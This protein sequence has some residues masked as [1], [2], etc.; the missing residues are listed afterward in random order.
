ML[1][2]KAKHRH[3]GRNSLFPN[4]VVEQHQGVS[5][6]RDDLIAGGT[7]ARYLIDLF[8][9]HDEV[10]YASPAY[11][12]AQLALAYCARLTGKRATVFVAKRKQPHNRT[13]EAARVGARV[14]QVVHGYLNVVQARAKAYAADMGVHLLPFGAHEER[15]IQAI[16]DVARCVADE[17]GVFDE[18]WCACG[19]GTLL[20]GLMR[21]LDAKR[22]V[23][24]QIGRDVQVSGAT[25][26]K[27]KLK[28]ED[29]SSAAVPFPS[30]PNYDR[31]AWELCRQ[32]AKGKVLFWNVIGASPT[33]HSTK[34]AE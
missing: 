23:G 16:A 4:P 31:K 13:L 14:F 19:S 12:G 29:E 6:V 7:K 34:L 20:T 18:V 15:A 8:S 27:H 10:V 22:F 26:I 25:I 3:T 21:G 2:P 1:K 33:P 11:G 17:H 9:Q 32:N 30:C 5:V 28:F 24:V